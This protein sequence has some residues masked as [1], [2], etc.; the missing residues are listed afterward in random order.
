M[1]IIVKYTLFYQRKEYIFFMK[2]KKGRIVKIVIAAVVVIVILV[3]LFGGKKSSTG[4][5]TEET[6]QIRDL[7]TYNKFTGN[8]T[9]KDDW[10]VVSDA[11][12]KVKEVKVEEGDEV[13]RGDV[14]AVLDSE[15]LEYNIK[16][17]ETSMELTDLTNLYNKRDAQKAYED[18]KSG[19]EAGDNQ[20]LL[21]ASTSLDNAR[22]ALETAQKNYNDAVE[23]QNDGSTLASVHEAAIR[24]NTAVGEA[25]AAYDENEAQIAKLSGQSITATGGDASLISSQLEVLLSKRASL[26]SALSAAK[27]SASAAYNTYVSSSD[28][29]DDAIEQYKTALDNAQTAYETAQKNYDATVKTVNQTL[30][31]YAN[32][33][34]KTTAL[35]STAVA[36]L[37]LEHMYDQLDDYTITAP[38]DGVITTLNISEGSMAAAGTAVAKITNYDV[39]QIEIKID[40]Y[41]ILGVEVGSD[42]QVSVDALD[43]TFPGKISKISKQA[44]VS[45]GVSYFTAEVEFDANENI[46]SGMSVEVKMIS[47]EAPS[48]VSISVDAVRNRTNNE[49]YVLMRGEDGKE[50][51]QDIKVGVSDGNYV[52]VTEGLNE[53]DV[54]LVSP[55]LGYEMMMGY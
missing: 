41:D 19:I 50:Y 17:K 11:S 39:M 3:V 30:E 21:S 10:D 34:E 49:A 45:G 28:N 23:G 44:T 51:E 43:E 36:V 26:S 20:Q 18:Y 12:A 52:Q 22:T 1:L 24:A 38:A 42:A 48:S 46:R 33:L 25:Q 29:L 37:E 14:I 31:N 13:K 7:T 54:V 32:A 35:S 9:A 8:I 16:L 47:R 2:K 4:I 15:T 40:E 5:Y 27:S 55:K 53:G 6:A